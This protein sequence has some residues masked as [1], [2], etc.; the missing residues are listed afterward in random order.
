MAEKTKTYPLTPAQKMHFY[1]Q[2]QCSG[3]PEVLN[4]GT[5]IFMN[6]EMDFEVLRDAFLKSYDR[7]EAAHIRFRKDKNGDICQYLSSDPMNEAE[8]LDFA[9]WGKTQ[10]EA[11]AELKRLTAIPMERFDSQMFRLYYV[12]M[13]NGYTGVFFLVDHM[14][15]DSSSIIVFI[16]DVIEIYCNAL[17]DTPY[18]KD[19]RSYIQSLEKDLKYAGSKA[20]ERDR[21][22]WEETVLSDE[23]IFTDILGPSRLDNARKETGDPD[24]RSAKVTS[25]TVV[26]DICNFSLEEEPSNK[27]MEYCKQ[28][29]V[30]MVCLLI[31]A[32]RTYLS[33]FNRYAEDIS[34]KTTVSRRGT[35]LEKKSGGTRIHF[36]PFRMKFSN[37]MKYI[38]SI[39][40]I[41]EMQN[42]IF[43]HA[44]YD[45]I[46]L[47]GE[48]CKRFG[49]QPG[50]SYDSVSLTYQPMSFRESNDMLKDID[51]EAK[52]LS[53]GV[54]AQPYYLTVMHNPETR[55]LDFFW[56]YQKGAVTPEQLEYIYY[57]LCKILFEVIEDDERTINEII[58]TV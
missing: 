3:H 7:Y 52:W 5:S 2:L 40:K 58:E 9:A 23:P 28:K 20:E 44:N 45:P 14:A 24:K 34:I 15:W 35:V 38:D 26:A 16:S 53:N 17:Y 13:P 31:S 8:F 12:R 57:Y 50:E 30:P 39:R 37:S 43:R 4:I 48:I 25:Q 54:A 49:N 56:E 42:K 11:E 32:L 21:Q 55:G 41:Q 27:L 29:N 46:K 36:F 19:L 33:K 47:N 1:T 18:P 6:G 51:Y 22:F 10:E